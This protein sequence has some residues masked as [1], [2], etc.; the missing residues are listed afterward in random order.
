METF[1]SILSRRKWSDL[2]A[3][4]GAYYLPFSGRKTRKEET[5][6]LSALL[7]AEGYARRR[8]R[9]LTVAERDPLRA[10]QAAGGKL[11]R[12][13]FNTAFGE[14]R[15]YRPW[16]YGS[17][18]QPWKQPQTLAE[19][20][21]FLG[22]VD[23]AD[24]E[25]VAPI[26]V[27]NLLPPLPHVEVSPIAATQ[28][29]LPQATF[30]LNDVA[31]LLGILL[32]DDVKALWGRWLPPRILKGLDSVFRIAG[33]EPN[34]RSELRTGR[35]RFVHYLAEAAGL[36]SI[37][38][39]YLKP[40]SAA[41][42]WL[43]ATSDEQWLTLWK[44]IERD[45]S[46]HSPLWERYRLPYVT[47]SLWQAL[48]QQLSGLSPD[49]GYDL[50]SLIG[51]LR[52]CLPGVSLASVPQLLEGLLSW[53]GIVSMRGE[54]TFQ[55]HGL[56]PTLLQVEN[57]TLH[58]RQGIYEE[59]FV[60]LPNFP[61]L[62]PLVE[63]TA[64]AKLDGNVIRIDANTMRIAS[65]H[66]CSAVQVADCLARLT[67]EGV[68]Q[69]AF[70]LLKTWESSAFRL[71]LE[72]QIVLTSPDEDLLASFL[73]DHRLRQMVDH[74][75]SAHHLSMKPEQVDQFTHALERRGIQITDHRPA[76][77]PTKHS[78]A[79]IDEDTAAYLWLAVRLYQ[80][81]D[82]F[83][84]P[85]VRLPGSVLDWLGTL[86]GNGEQ[87]HLE[88]TA[89]SLL[90]AL[91]YAADND[92]SMLLT[93]PIQQQ[94]AEAIRANVERAIQQKSALV[95]DYFSPAYGM[96]KRRTI[97]PIMAIVQRGDFAYIE[98]WCQEAEDERTF[99]LDRIV[100]VVDFQEGL[101]L[102]GRSRLSAK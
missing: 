81:L 31:T 60:Q 32:Y 73:T 3:I 79:G 102:A 71:R 17:P 23:F 62:R 89:E 56:P 2:R 83:A 43:D 88:Q 52:P 37:Q 91:A 20:L 30:L 7:N 48:E 72:H 14:V 49:E 42:I 24:D 51:A 97:E 11:P 63:L 99:R 84:Q 86:L 21:W 36:I 39:G 45:L 35:I 75:L 70:N 90:D 44:S 13:Q 47:V 12:A 64:W 61:R 15:P 8:F 38:M 76:L 41:W 96:M 87:D 4:A 29:P 54:D 78:L 33:E 74:S 55:F 85:A 6:R 10:L 27:L 77:A 95:I 34:V 68:L 98:A 22:F 46:N 92:G 93:A 94:D 65:Q 9:Q 57:A 53:L 58:V 69:E 28:E 16:R 82:V 40:T 19:K 100:R 26:E 5:E 67:G 101:R 18:R 66:H 25:V 1:T 50:I 59:L 80:G